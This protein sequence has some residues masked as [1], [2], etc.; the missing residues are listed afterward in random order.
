MHGLY[1]AIRF[2][3]YSVGAI[4]I[5]KSWN[6]LTEDVDPVPGTKEFAKELDLEKSKMNIQRFK[7]LGEMNPE[8]LWSTTLDPETRNLLQ[9][10][11]SKDLKKDQSLIHTLMG[12]DVALRRDFIISNAINVQNLDI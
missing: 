5:R 11:Y 12:N 1:S 8:E 9:V 2:I 10:Q 4:V 3:A 7:G 6:W